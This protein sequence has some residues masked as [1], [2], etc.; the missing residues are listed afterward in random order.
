MHE[1]FASGETYSAL[2]EVNRNQNHLW[3]P[4]KQTPWKFVVTGYNQTI[5][6]TRQRMVVEG[7]SY[8]ALE[9]HIDLVRPE[10]QLCVFEEC[11]A[12]YSQHNVTKKKICNRRCKRQIIIETKIRRGR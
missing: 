9:G 1:Y 3:K 2:H 6:K 5:P 11:K 12:F 7:F 8:M 10:L 4:Y